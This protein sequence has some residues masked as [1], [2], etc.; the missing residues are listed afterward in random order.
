MD[1]TQMLVLESGPH[2][3]GSR[4]PHDDLF[5][6]RGVGPGILT[7]A[8]SLL[9]RGV[10]EKPAIGGERSLLDLVRLPILRY[11][12]RRQLDRSECSFR[13]PVEGFCG[14]G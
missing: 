13:G 14:G 10:H 4:F 2:G 5:R 6:G 11:F 9:Y 7:N 8:V 1:L 3:T 12:A